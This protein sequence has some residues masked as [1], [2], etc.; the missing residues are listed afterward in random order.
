MPNTNDAINTYF[1]IKGTLLSPNLTKKVVGNH[2]KDTRECY[3]YT[4][5]DPIVADSTI[6]EDII[7]CF[8]NPEDTFTPK[9]IKE[10]VQED[11][12]P[13]YIN[14]K[15]NYI[16]KVLTRDESGNEVPFDINDLR[17]GATGYFTIKVNQQPQPKKKGD[18]DTKYD[19]AIYLS[20]FLMIENGQPKNLYAG[21]DF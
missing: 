9:W 4:I 20:S 5:K 13:E 17:V 7:S 10:L 11:K 1:I 2:A 19:T 8:T 3:R 16:L 15:S 21:C 6:W 14:F 18:L 12:A